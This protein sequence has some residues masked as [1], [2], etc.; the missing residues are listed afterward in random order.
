M[1]ASTRLSPA[2]RSGYSDPRTPF[3]VSLAG[4]S[5]A[6]GGFFFLHE[7][8]WLPA[9]MR[10]HFPGVLSP[11]WRLYHNPRSGWQVIHDGRS[12]RLAPDEL[13]LIP[14]GT[15]FDCV[16]EAGVPHLWLHFD[17][18]TPAPAVASRPIRLAL[19]GAM[20]AAARHLIAGHRARASAG[21][22]YH[23]AA[24]LLHL[25]FGALDA[26]VLAEYPEKLAALLLFIRQHPDADL[27]NAALARRAAL[28]D[29]AFIRWFR[30]AVGV[31][32][33]LYVQ[34]ARIRTAAHSLAR[35]TRSID[36]IAAAT[37]FKNRHHFSRVFK[38]HFHCGPA[39]YRRR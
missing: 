20:P 32:P 38:Q 1:A 18:A 6:A 16:G 15:V 17:L 37:G 33:A 8:G 4:P 31:T 12:W 34:R 29:G 21:A 11:F 23:S 27:T 30:S 28:S 25:A 26:A 5:R 7:T 10:W 14:D 3:G 13:L 39:A 9:G 36:E 22:L 24:A 35:T 2:Q 19:T